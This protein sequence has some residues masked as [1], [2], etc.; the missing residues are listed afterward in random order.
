M[1]K[2]VSIRYPPSLSLLSPSPSLL[3]P[4]LPLPPSLPPSLS[5]LSLLPLPPLS[6][7]RVYEEADEPE[8]KEEAEQDKQQDEVRPK[9]GSESTVPL[10][11][12]DSPA[13]VGQMPTHNYNEH[14]HV[15]ARLF[16]SKGEM[17][18]RVGLLHLYIKMVSDHLF[19][20]CPSPPLPSPPLP[21]LGEVPGGAAGGDEQQDPGG[22]PLWTQGVGGCL[23]DTGV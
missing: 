11:N 17:H 8:Q 2:C 7:Q 4:S 22:S 13:K 5:S 15:P 10:C 6:L 9:E 23:R 18:V 21:S 12:T 14:V 20:S 16:S 19:S 3:L 1:D